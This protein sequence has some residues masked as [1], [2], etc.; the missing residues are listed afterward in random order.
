M[1]NRPI[2]M[3]NC[4]QRIPCGEVNPKA[5][6]TKVI[7]IPPKKLNERMVNKAKIMVDLPVPQPRVLSV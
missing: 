4:S 3:E 1:K 2:E 6:L 7:P 5:L